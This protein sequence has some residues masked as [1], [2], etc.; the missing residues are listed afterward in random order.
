M[1]T[2]AGWYPDPG[3]S[4]QQ[5]Y[6]DGAQWS[7]HYA[8]APPGYGFAPPAPPA[9]PTKSGGSRTV[10]KIAALIGVLVLFGIIANIDTGDKDST[11]SS[12]SSTRT[13]PT[14]SGAID[15]TATAA[16]EPSGSK[17]APAASAVRDGK[18]EFQIVSMSRGPKAGDLSNQ[19]M[20]ET[21]QGEFVVLTVRVT[22]I[23][24]E[25]QSY[26]GS[27]QKLIDTAG[28]EYAPNSSVDLWLNGYIGDINPGNSVQVVMAFDVPPGTPS[29]ALELHDS[30][31]SAG[32]QLATGP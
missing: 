9:P 31:F 27:N 17:I 5:R 6:F 2:P 1:T 18:F 25:P 24:N 19:F 26:F 4:G 15:A 3:G 28:R 29:Q 16:A 12:T 13:L 23:G 7:A 10:L 20:T 30:M 21:A 11:A 32:T 8:P 22:N 14:A